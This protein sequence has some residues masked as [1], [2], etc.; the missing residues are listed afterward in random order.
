MMYRG[1]TDLALEARQQVQQGDREVEGVAFEQRD[2]GPAHVTRVTVLDERGAKSLQKPPG[3]YITIE[4]PS[5]RDG[6]SDCF[7]EGCE[8]L[9]GEL[10]SL[11]PKKEGCVLVAGLGNRAVT[12][13]ALGPITVENLLITRHLVNLMPKDFG[14]F[15]PVCAMCP[16]V[17]G[18]TGMETAEMLQG[19]INYV[20]P[21]F[22][23]AVDALAARSLS[24][25]G[26]TFQL[27]DTGIHPGSGVGNK[28]HTLSQETLGIPVL[29]VGVPTVVDAATLACDVMDQVRHAQGQNQEEDYGQVIQALSPFSRELMVTP[30]EIDTLI[31]EA[32]KVLGYG[33]SMALLELSLSE[34]T[35]MLN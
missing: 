17:M 9:R 20:R 22:V 21:D 7:K 35:A 32:A 24:R 16:G 18:I 27:C 4:L 5:M 26:T 2:Q 25:L 33:L 23:I 11:F 28:R 30:K 31:G 8:V 10:L 14:K 1:R 12:P 19:V 3:C 29:S 6:V 13:D 15:R 34:V